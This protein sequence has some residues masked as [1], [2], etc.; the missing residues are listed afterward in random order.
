[1]WR[2]EPEQKEAL[3]HLVKCSISRLLVTPLTWIIPRDTAHYVILGREN[4]LFVDNCKYFYIWLHTNR[5][6]NENIVFITKKEKLT[7]QIRQ[8]GGKA[9]LYPS[10]PAFWHLLRAGTWVVDTM[11]W[12]NN[13][14]LGFSR[15]ARS[16]Q[17]WHGVPLKE[18][19]LPLYAKRLARL[20]P[21]KRTMLQAYKAITARYRECDYLVSTSAFLSEQAFRPC[22]HAKAIVATGYPRN[23]ILFNAVDYDQKLINI[24]TDK[25]ALEQLHQHRVQ[26]GKTVLYAPTFRKDRH[27]PFE[28]GHINLAALS[29][30][31][32]EN[33]LLFAM[34][35]HPLMQ[36]RY[37]TGDTPGII[38]IEPAS[39]AYP[40]LAE[41][42]ALITD[43]SSIYFDYLLLD[44]PVLFYPYDFESYTTDDRALLFEYVAMAP[45]PICLTQPQLLGALKNWLENMG[46]EH[47]TERQRVRRFVFDHANGNASRRLKDII[48][49]P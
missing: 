45:G 22:F 7:E 21:C 1:M 9:A 6:Q 15:G 24:N 18:I 38:H 10:L 2:L 44:R 49:A 14:R 28:Q 36:H 39:D 42:D 27:N 3:L 13:G 4:G 17:L 35:L 16:V 12:Q 23:D 20:S 41:I 19:E 33:N 32:R 34:K 40:L 5:T 37:R 30:F 8:A 25:A 43:Y 47:F 31:S 46:D 26:G 11:D 48:S 29:H